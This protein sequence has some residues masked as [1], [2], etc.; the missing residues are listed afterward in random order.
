M[1]CNTTSYQ[2]YAID[3]IIKII[4]FIKMVI[5]YLESQSVISLYLSVIHPENDQLEI[6]SKGI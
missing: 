6:L 1:S 5:S 4:F 2:T 3:L